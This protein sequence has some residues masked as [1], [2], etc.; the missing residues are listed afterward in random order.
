MP[1][2][3]PLILGIF[4]GSAVLM[5]LGLMQPAGAVSVPASATADVAVGAIREDADSDKSA[6]TTKAAVQSKTTVSTP[7]LWQ[8]FRLFTSRLWNKLTMR[9]A[10]MVAKDEEGKP[11]N[12][13]KDAPSND[14]Q[15]PVTPPKEDQPAMK[16]MPGTKV[17]TL[18]DTGTT[19]QL[20]R[21]Q[22]FVLKLGEGY[23]WQLDL[24]DSGVLSRIK[25]IAVLRDSQ[26][27]FV[28]EKPGTATLTATGEPECRNSQP[29]CGQPS[30]MFNLNVEVAGEVS[31]NPSTMCTMEY[32]PVCGLVQ[33]QCIKAPCPPLWQTFSNNCMAKAAGAM[34]IVPGACNATDAEFKTGVGVGSKIDLMVR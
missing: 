3:K 30:I 8:R 4:L 14:F 18:A 2:L 5:P 15:N 17:V 22:R 7:G 11:E 32:K 27:V 9:R 6:I 34:Q 29:A 13:P 28:A 31:A 33:V 20:K 1:T 25:N 26:G 24:D 10:Q 21:G 23:N 16:Q 12:T 19:L